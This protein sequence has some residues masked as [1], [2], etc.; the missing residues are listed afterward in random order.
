MRDHIQALGWLHVLWGAF[1][2]LAGASLALLAVGTRAALIG[3]DG[4]GAD[5]VAAVWVLAVCGAVLAAAGVL[6]IAVGRSLCRRSQAGRLAALV[7]ALPNLVLVPFGTAL[8]GYA[9][10]VLLN[11]D[12]RREFG[13][14]P[15]RRLHE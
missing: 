15:R 4:G 11:D 9:L 3:L 14:P 5:G 7:F 8:G 12:A 10:W 6:M 13:R 1:G 2:V